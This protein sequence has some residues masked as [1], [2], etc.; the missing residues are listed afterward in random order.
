M[1][2]PK[3]WLQDPKATAEVLKKYSFRFQKKFGQNF[4]IDSHVLDKIITAADIKDDDMILE[5]G[6]GIGRR[7]MR[8]PEQ[9]ACDIRVAGIFVHILRVAH[10]HG[11]QQQTVGFQNRHVRKNM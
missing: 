7:V 10:A 5:I 3:P 4:L 1:N 8:P 11:A 6:P 2:G 9:V